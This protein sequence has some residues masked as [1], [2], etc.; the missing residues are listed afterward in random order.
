MSD[1]QP[2]SPFSSTDTAEDTAPEGGLPPAGGG[3]MGSGPMGRLFDGSAPGPPVGQIESD[4]GVGKPWSIG[5]RGVVRTATGEGVP[6]IVE[7]GLA[8]AAGLAKIL[9]GDANTD[10]MMPEGGTW[11]GRQG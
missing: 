7:I 2:D 3:G 4:Y 11:D 8:S 10:E 5:L 1:E 6:P 9:R